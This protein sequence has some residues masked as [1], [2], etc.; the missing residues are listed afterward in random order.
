MK[1]FIYLTVLPL[2]ALTSIA[3][4]QTFAP[5]PGVPWPATDALGRRLPTADEVGPSKPDRFVGIFY[6]LW[7][8]Q[9]DGSTEGP[10]DVSKIMAAH[11]DALQTPTSPPWGPAG[12]M[13]FWNEPLF[14]YY[15]NADPWVLRRHAHLLADAGV[16]VLIFDTTNRVTYKDVY[17]KLCEVFTEV[18]AA[19]GHTPQI[20]FMTNTEAGATADELYKDLYEPGLYKELWFHWEGKPLLI[21]D[22]AAASET[23]KGFFTLRKAHW[24]FEMVNTERAWHWEATY[25]QPY[26]FT[27]D[28]NKPEQVNVSVAQNLRASDG[29]VTD[30]SRGDARGRTFHKGAIDRSPDAILHG[31][32]FAEQWTRAWELDPPIVMVTGWNEWIAGSFER[33]GLPVAFVDQFDA[34]NSRDIEMM[35]GGH[36]DNYYYQLVDGIRRYKGAPALP[37]ASAPVTIP[38]TEDFAP[39]NG[40]EPLYT[41]APDDTIARDYPGVNKLHYTN[42]TGRNELL[43]FK[44]ARDMDNLYFYAATGKDLSPTEGPNWMH[45]LIDADQNPATGWLGYDFLVSGNTLHRHQSPA[46]GAESAFT[47]RKVQDITKH[48][49]KRELHLAIPRAALGLMAG[50]SPVRF[51]FK[52]A[53]NLQNPND[54]MDF[55][56]SGDVAPDGRF[57]Y[58]YSAN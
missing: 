17:M 44:V 6:F 13:H 24:P 55:Y 25:P 38:I 29:K 42:T 22:P 53:D 18:R 33:E 54:P 56:V 34:A 26:G 1:Y 23:V 37:E 52:W 57:N 15:R 2:V 32:N 41:D 10:F 28:P 4:A 30:M 27:D 14:G 50:D 19:G 51:D 36:G 47:W 58:R 11:P 5:N 43:N 49:D 40:V 12:H 3:S 9:H 31:Y 46:E 21:V 16:D 7:N 20:T 8:G 48:V 45:L 39:W 35:K